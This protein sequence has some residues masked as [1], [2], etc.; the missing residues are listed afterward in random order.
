MKLR[1][2]FITGSEADCLYFKSQA[3][4]KKKEREEKRARGIRL[5]RVKVPLGTLIE[6]NYNK[7]FA[8]IWPIP[9]VYY[10]YDK[11]ET[12]VKVYG[13]PDCCRVH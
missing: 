11:T 1:S 6:R 12:E 7:P 2:F 9:S 8:R 13:A 4:K 3:L 10:L 5:A